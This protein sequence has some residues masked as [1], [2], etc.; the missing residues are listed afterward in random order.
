MCHLK[1]L[2]A[3]QDDDKEEER[4]IQIKANHWYPKNFATTTRE[5][6]CCHKDD[7]VCIKMIQDWKNRNGEIICRIGLKEIEENSDGKDCVN[8]R[9]KNG[10]VLNLEINKVIFEIEAV[11]IK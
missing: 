3:G 5:K 11:N 2:S 8:R 10:N 6:E 7:I 9:E 1:K 4:I